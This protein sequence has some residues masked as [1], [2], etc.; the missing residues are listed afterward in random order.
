MTNNCDCC[1]GVRGIRP[2]CVDDNYE[3]YLCTACRRMLTAAGEKV[4]VMNRD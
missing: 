4:E 1:G 3:T 2:V